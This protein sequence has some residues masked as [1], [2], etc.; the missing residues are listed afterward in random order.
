MDVPERMQR[1][2]RDPRRGIPVPWFVAW[3]DGQPDYRVIGPGKL[4]LGIRFG[5]CWLC[6]YPIGR[7]GSF[8][9]GPM[10]SVT[11]TNSEPPSHRDC[12]IYA[13]VTC[14]FLT[15]PAMRRR[16]KGLP[17]DAVEPAGVGLRRNPG[18]VAVWSTRKWSLFSDCR[19]GT[20]VKMGDPTEVLWYAE[21]R[22]ATRAEVEASIESGLPLLEA[23]KEGPAAA[24]EL[25]RLVDVARR[26]LPA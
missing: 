16:E 2:P 8:V 4:A 7:N 3:I 12:A 22:A 13:A 9:I 26:Y 15:R 21:G 11:R 19:G 23:D 17:E 14:P 5:H 20:L 1:L 24:A 25:G 10:C 6:G 18:V